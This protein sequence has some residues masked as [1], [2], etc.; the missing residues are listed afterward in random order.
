MSVGDV[1]KLK[2]IIENQQQWLACYKNMQG[3]VTDFQRKL[4][5]LEPRTIRVFFTKANTYEDLASWRITRA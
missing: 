3:V 5:S 1:V 2:D 4:R